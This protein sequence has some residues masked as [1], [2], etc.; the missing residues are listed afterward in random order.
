MFL[1]VRRDKG[2]C[3]FAQHA[4]TFVTS[5]GLKTFEVIEGAVHDRKKQASNYLISMEEHNGTQ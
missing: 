1:R 3:F 4:G 5:R 2:L